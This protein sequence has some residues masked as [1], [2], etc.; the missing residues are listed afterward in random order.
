M[1]GFFKTVRKGE[2]RVI[3]VAFF[4]LFFILAGH[5]LLETAR[6]ALF[7]ASIPVSKLPLMYLGIAFGSSVI[8]VLGGKIRGGAKT[9]LIATSLFA[10]ALM[11]LIY[12]RLPRLG[13]T[14]IYILYIWTG[15]VVTVTLLR[16]WVLLGSH[17]TVTQARR[18]YP[19]IGAG[20]VAGAIAGSGTAR[21]ITEV[22]PTPVL[23]SVA[24]LSFFISALIASGLPAA[25]L[26]G[27]VS[28]NPKECTNYVF[29]HVYARRIA[30]FVLLGS[31]TTTFADYVFKTF[32]AQQVAASDLD[33]FFATLYFSLNVASLIVQI[34]LARWI[35]ARFNVVFTIT[36]LPLFLVAGGASLFLI[37]GLLAATA[38]KSVDGTFRHS[39]HKTATELLF[40]PLS[41]SA[42]GHLKVFTDVMS[43]KGGQ[44]LASA[45][46][47]VLPLLTDAIEIVVLSFFVFATSW[48]VVALMLRKPYL[49]SVR[50]G[51]KTRRLQRFRFA[52]LDV[53]SLESILRALD[54]S[55]DDDVIA[56][57]DLLEAQE[58]VQLIPRLMLRHHSPKV[59]LRTLSIFARAHELRV[60]ESVRALY[61][62]EHLGVRARAMVTGVALGDSLNLTNAISKDQP[63]VI[64]GIILTELWAQNR[65]DATARELARVLKSADKSCLVYISETIGHHDDVLFD[66]MLLGLIRHEDPGVRS[67]TL[68]ALRDSRRDSLIDVIMEALRYHDSRALATELLINFGDKA[69]ERLL[70]TWDT[71]KIEDRIRTEIPNVLAHFPNDRVANEVVRRL[72]K[73]KNGKVRYRSLRALSRMVRRNM[74]LELNE[75]D[76][77]TLLN[78]AI[79]YAYKNVYRAEILRRIGKANPEFVTAGHT[80]LLRLLD[81]KYRQATGRAFRVLSL[82]YPKDD[83][84]AIW[85][86]IISGDADN[87]ASALELLENRLDEPFRSGIRGLIDDL[88][89]KER[90]TLGI[91]FYAREK[92]SYA[93]VVSEMARSSSESVRV[94]A[95]HH[96][97][98]LT[99]ADI[100]IERVGASVT[101]LTSIQPPP[102]HP[103]GLK[104]A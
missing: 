28:E 55:A 13:E 36:L 82:R 63:D 90:L 87:R 31:I 29:T 101:D 62:H 92:L 24:S 46:L 58:R 35:L 10:S 76:V 59:I 37:P 98:E 41:D 86:S 8:T 14:G 5:A 38:V 77:I 40:A 72:L 48:L 19:L 4:V 32:V 52:A 2:G 91:K 16:F 71:A 68:G 96:L 42:R 85:Q 65:D 7:L 17:L 88:T 89:A 33:T 75:N 12:F 44:A 45:M 22:M 3:V 81:D 23:I 79:V 64:R 43:Q 78:Q 51:L 80:L 84:D 102:L 15:I 25:S 66:E 73:E 21:A 27:E 11:L 93:D 9:Q 18:L 70:H 49:D 6:D 74:S 103:V 104:P 39:L 47:L 20:S 26:D 69:V 56:A 54:S 94:L 67:S 100:D 50:T 30:I 99:V 61:D 95:Q 1:K 83:M 57:L 53:A 34:V 60:L 97:E